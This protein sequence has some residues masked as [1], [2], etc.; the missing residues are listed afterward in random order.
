MKLPP[1][2][3]GHG[4]RLMYITSANLRAALRGCDESS[5]RLYNRCQGL[6]LE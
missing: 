3:R 5:G 4:R 1:A 2:A 6:V